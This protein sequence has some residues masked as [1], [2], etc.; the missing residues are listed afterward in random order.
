[1]VLMRVLC[2]LME[3]SCLPLRTQV[4]SLALL[5]KDCSVVVEAFVLSLVFSLPVSLPIQAQ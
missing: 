2:V 3:L 4:V 1:M 5:Q